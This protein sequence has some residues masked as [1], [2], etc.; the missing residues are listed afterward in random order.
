M[1]WYYICAICLFFS[2]T[3]SSVIRLKMTRRT[4]KW[5]ETV[6]MFANNFVCTLRVFEKPC[7]T[8]QSIPLLIVCWRRKGCEVCI[9][10]VKRDSHT[11]FSIDKC[12]IGFFFVLKVLPWECLYKKQSHPGL[13]FCCSFVPFEVP[14]ETWISLLDEVL[15]CVVVS[16]VIFFLLLILYPDS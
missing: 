12:F 4:W 1:I 16:V 3:N 11:H 10:R 6:A 15:L 9:K 14:F 2:S 5:H 13:M 8:Q 7:V